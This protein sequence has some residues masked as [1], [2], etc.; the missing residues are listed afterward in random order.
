M[1][2]KIFGFMSSDL[3]SGNLEKADKMLMEEIRKRYELIIINP[4]KI[5]YK[6]EKSKLSMFID[7][8]KIDKID[9][10]LIRRTRGAEEKVYEAAKFMEKNGTKVLDKP[11]FLLDALSKFG[12]TLDRFEGF[13]SPST[14]YC[15]N[16][17][18]LRKYLFDNKLKFPLIVKPYKGYHGED[19]IKIDSNGVF[20]KY[21]KDYFLNGKEN[22]FFQEYINIK[23][24]YR[25]F[26]IGGKSLGV[27][28]KISK[29]GVI[30]KNYALGSDFIKV[31]RPKV[32]RLAEKLCKKLKTSFS[33]VDII[34]D[35]EGK[36][37]ILECNRSPQFIGFME[38]TG[39][40]IAKKI[41]EYF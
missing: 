19:V 31:N 28:E 24:E 30:A 34:E 38:A 7:G 21:V 18:S 8:K 41:I 32:E 33:G 29:E 25:V 17:E 39:I 23:H 5:L 1:R 26:V 20:M 12:S 2:K 11:A 6:I 22:F 9:F 37:Y 40:D 3:L 16:L 14:Y 4:S 35:E 10:A 36:L 13:S 15:H 27:A